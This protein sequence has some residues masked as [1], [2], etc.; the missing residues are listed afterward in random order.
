MLQR[1][2]I[3][4]ARGQNNCDIFISNFAPKFT[5]KLLIKT[6]FS[7]LYKHWYKGKIA[8]LYN[9]MYFQRYG[10]SFTIQFPRKT[11]LY[12]ND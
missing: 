9:T 4:R 8:W 11:F 3:L 12:L 10:L 6:Y 7:S 2:M 1:A 5:Y